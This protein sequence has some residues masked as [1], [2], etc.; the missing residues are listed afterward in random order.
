MGSGDLVQTDV[1][2]LLSFEPQDDPTGLAIVDHIERRRCT[3]ETGHSV[4]PQPTSVDAFYFPVDRG[5]S[6]TT[7]QVTL[8]HT[9]A[10]CLRNHAGFMI[11]ELTQGDSRDFPS[12]LY[13]IELSAPIKLYVVIEA[14][15][16]V[17]V[18]TDDVTI[19]FD[20]PVEVLIGA[21]SHHKHP[22]ATIETTAKAADLMEAVSYLS[23]ALKTTSVERSYPTLRGHPPTIE[24]GDSHRI[25]EVLQRPETGVR[26]ELPADP[27]HIF[28][29]STLAYY[30]GAE[31]VPAERP[32]LVTDIG[33]VHELDSPNRGFEEEVERV[34]KQVFFL[35]CITRTEGFYPVNLHERN[36]IED[37]VGLNFEY[38][39]DQPIGRQLR[40]YL[41]VPYSI[42]EPHI[43]QWKLTANVVPIPKHIEMLP[44]L[45]N[46]L[47][48]VRSADSDRASNSPSLNSYIDE[49]V[50][51]NAFTRSSQERSSSGG[52][53]QPPVIDL[54]ESNSLEQTWVG[55]GAP[56]GAS[57][58]VIEAFFNRLN[59]TPKRGDIEITVICND[60]EMSGERDIVEEIYGSRENL[61]FDVELYK[62]LSKDQLKDILESDIDFLH[63]IGHI[64]D[65]GF[66]CADGYFDA[67]NLDNS[68]VDSFFLNACSSY[69]Q[70]EK[71]LEA[72]SI[73]GI[74]TLQDII[75]SGAERIGHTLAKLLN[76]GFPI[77]GALNL[78]K[79]QS[80][81]G[82]HYVV[83]GD[84]G[85]N[86]VQT[87]SGIAQVCEINRESNNKF[88]LNFKTY[89]TQQKSIGTLTF[90]FVKTNTEYYLSS[91]NS[92]SF[93]L[94][95]EDLIDFLDKEI[96]P[97]IWDNGLSWSNDL[98]FN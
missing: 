78:A 46:D 34:L 4:D 45:V 64:D 27:S 43:P 7:D 86:V 28:V 2:T 76:R 93:L 31:M 47:A 48:V 87:E 65:N 92:G 51:A 94:E 59:R 32:R 9:V 22:A 40:E 14:A 71:L 52:T 98:N 61:P 82:G 18:T 6:I 21:R 1:E 57:K 54:D 62:E 25:P 79:N 30:L 29:A 80:I 42:L 44:F 38:L 91:G 10:V 88:N 67:D 41:E 68:G 33:F 81:M 70:G 16:S 11:D 69:R 95:I 84:P 17:A 73:C 56:M 96:M 72:G 50:R 8:P 23:S 49:F 63:Y 55:E 24:F 60:P 19:S 90:P 35:D 75:N 74:V 26:L 77:Q 66:E 36:A 13:S 20:A 39:Y 97:V 5:V 89:P 37:D 12:D 58:A 3:L 15:P 85:I 53:K 83:I